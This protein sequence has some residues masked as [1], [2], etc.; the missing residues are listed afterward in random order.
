[1]AISATSNI[2]ADKIE[3]TIQIIEAFTDYERKDKTSS[4]KSGNLLVDKFVSSPTIEHYNNYS[5]SGHLNGAVSIQP[6]QTVFTETVA[7]AATFCPSCNYGD[8]EPDIDAS[9]YRRW[10]DPRLQEKIDII[11]DVYGRRAAESKR[12]NPRDPFQFARQRYFDPTA[13]H[14]VGHDLNEWE[15]RDAFNSEITMILA[16]RAGHNLMRLHLADPIFEGRGLGRSDPNVPRMEL[17]STDR[18]AATRV[19]LMRRAFNNQLNELFE[20]NGIKIPDNVRLGFHIDWSHRLTV[21]GTDDKDLI[22]QIEEVLNRNGNASRLWGHIFS[23][24]RYGHI[25]NTAEPL[26]GQLSSSHERLIWLNALLRDYTG[27]CMRC[28]LTLVDGRLLTE[29]GDDIIDIAANVSNRF[30]A[31]HLVEQLAWLASAGG[32]DSI[33]NLTLTIEFENGHLFDYQQRFGFGPGQT[34]WIDRLPGTMHDDN[35]LN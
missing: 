32:I 16:K 27:Y 29:N 9:D 10:V 4:A 26:S 2:T 18:E 6:Q 24:T 12:M 1:M 3:R 31:A 35:L 19:L 30:I 21:T 25:I 33:T 13:R 20:R 28:D 5:K 34:G 23:S 7:T 14:F 17:L 8:V 11:R 22:K 15:R